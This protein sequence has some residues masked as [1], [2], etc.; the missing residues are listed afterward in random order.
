M[1]KVKG[2]RHVLTFKLRN[3]TPGAV[4]YS[5]VDAKGSEAKAGEGMVVGTLYVRKDQLGDTPPQ[6][7]KVTVEGA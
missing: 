5:E 3:E 4:R 7:L 1:A 6:A 2:V